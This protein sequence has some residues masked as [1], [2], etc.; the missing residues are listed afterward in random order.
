VE[1]HHAAAE[2]LPVPDDAFDAV[3]A[4]LVVH[5]MRDPQAGV[6]EMTRVA[7]PGGV[8]GACVWDNAGDTGPLSLF[9]RAA[10][11]LD[12]ATHDESENAGSQAGDL[13]R[14][15][16][17]AGLADVEGAVLTIR[18]PFAD[19]DE[20]W[21]PFTLGVGPAGDYV[22]ALDAAGRD[23]LR[24]ACADLLPAP[25]FELAASAWC[26]TGRVPR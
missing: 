20:W 6:R 17:A 22:A 10:R 19:V 13:E 5:F 23:E 2:A 1:V 9:W 3:A 25:P 24:A 26:A 7:R 18:V 8:V 14:L 12:P 16:S 4:Q 15:L 21:E 11:S